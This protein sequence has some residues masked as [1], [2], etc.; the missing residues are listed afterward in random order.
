MRAIAYCRVSTNE[1]AEHGVSLAAQESKL[2][3]YCTA[4]EIE[5]VRVEVDAGVSASTLNRLALQRSLASLKNGE[6][7]AIVITKLDRISRSVVDLCS[8]V[9]DYFRDDRRALISLAES[10]DTKSAS[11]RLVLNLLGV[12]AQW[13]REQVGERT[14]TAMRHMRSEGRYT[15]GFVPFGYT[16]AADSQTLVE[17]PGEQAVIREARTLRA[18]GMS[19]RAIAATLSERGAFLRGRMGVSQ[20]QRMLASAA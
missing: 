16:L 3:A 9:D 10:I 20:V 7:D 6:A 8:L 18:T 11:G 1:Q 17:A 12:V 5:L 4:L 14:S 2:R 19:Y 15:G 13:E